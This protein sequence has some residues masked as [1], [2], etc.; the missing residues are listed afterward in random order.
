MKRNVLRSASSSKSRE[1]LEVRCEGATKAALN[2]VESGQERM[3]IHDHL[4]LGKHTHFRLDDDG[5]H[6]RDAIKK[7]SAI[8]SSSPRENQVD[9]RPAAVVVES[10]GKTVAAPRRHSTGSS[11]MTILERPSAAA[12]VAD[13]S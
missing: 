12:A 7:G 4:Q 6:L 9:L 13:P 1:Y 2:K 8:F 10:V 3:G 11:Q 5:H